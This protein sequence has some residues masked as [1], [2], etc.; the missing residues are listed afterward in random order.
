MDTTFSKYGLPLH[1]EGRDS[2]IFRNVGNVSDYT[3]VTFQEMLILLIFN[4]NMHKYTQAMFSVIFR[5][6][7]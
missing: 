1:F 4:L 7:T 2:T 3:E 6:I 5:Q